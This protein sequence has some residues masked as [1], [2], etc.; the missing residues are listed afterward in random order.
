[1][2]ESTGT[3][4]LPPRPLGGKLIVETAAEGSAAG[5]PQRDVTIYGE[6]KIAVG[7]GPAA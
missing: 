1:M 5:T 7:N 2:A 3:L 4:E 6:L